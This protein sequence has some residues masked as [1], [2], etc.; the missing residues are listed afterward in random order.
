MRGSYL[1]NDRLPK[2]GEKV[3]ILHG[4]NRKVVSG[5][6]ANV[7]DIDHK[8][9]ANTYIDVSTKLGRLHT[10]IESV[11]DHKPR[12]VKHIDSFGEIEVWE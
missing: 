12:L 9:L 8:G 6:V 11:F 1:E 3:F 7:W 10:S 5:V 2:I 4:F